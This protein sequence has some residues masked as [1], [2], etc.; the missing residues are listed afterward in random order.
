MI[1]FPDILRKR[2]SQS[3]YVKTFPVNRELALL[4]KNNLE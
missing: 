2:M 3:I 1:D 4:G